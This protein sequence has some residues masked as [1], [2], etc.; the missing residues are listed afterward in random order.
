VGNN[1]VTVKFTGTYLAIFECEFSDTAAS[2]AVTPVIAVSGSGIA[3]AASRSAATGGNIESRTVTWLGDV[4][5]GGYIE[6]FLQGTAN[7]TVYGTNG[8]RL[9]VQRLA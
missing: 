3:Q 8:T 6:A 7:T 1:R 2:Q 9:V 4:S 5:V